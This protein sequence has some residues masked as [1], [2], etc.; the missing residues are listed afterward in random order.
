MLPVVE[1]GKPPQLRIARA[2][3]GKSIDELD[4]WWRTSLAK[5]R[6]PESRRGKV[7]QPTLEMIQALPELE[8]RALVEEARR[9]RGAEEEA[10]RQAA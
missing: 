2:I 6:N 3:I 8:K 7:L 1:G 10:A 5:E 4:E 9:A